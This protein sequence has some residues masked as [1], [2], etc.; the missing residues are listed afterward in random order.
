MLH[1]ILNNFCKYKSI[2]NKTN[3]GFL[4][5]ILFVILLSSCEKDSDIKNNIFKYNEYSNISSLDPAFSSTLRNIWPVNQIFNGLVQLDKNLEIKGDIASSW[6]ISEDKRTYTFKI[7][8]DV[9]FHNSELFGKNLTR[10]VK[11]KD[12]EYSFN[13][14]IDNKIASPGYWVLNNVKDF[15]AIND[16]IFQIEL[17]KEF[18]PFLGI[19]SMKYCSVVPHEIITV[20]GDKFSKKPIGTGPFKFKKW[21]EN[22]KLVL[23]KNKNY[24]ENDSLGQ[25]LPYLDGIAISFIPDKK[26]EFME[27]LSGRLDMVSSPDNSIIDQIF[28]YKGDLNPRFSSNYN[29]LKSP[30]LNTEYIG[31]NIQNNIKKDTLLRYAI[32]SGID[33]KKMMQYLRKNIGYPA[34]S[35]IVPNGLNNSFYSLRYNYDPDLSKKL[36]S[37]YKSNNDIDEINI[38]IFS[39]SQYLD[40]LEFIQSELQK[41][42]VQIQIEITPPSILRQGKATG[43]FDAFRA[44][45]IADYPHV[46]NYFSLF[47]SKNHTPKGPNYT[48]FSDRNFDEL[49]ELI[50][51][52]KSIS[53][54]KISNDLENILR[55]YSPIIPLY[56]DMSVRIVPKNI[57]GLEANAINQLN[58][59]RVMKKL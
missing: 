42:G 2:S 44:S 32:N 57:S 48:F 33:R 12:F 45:W 1:S 38:T 54:E 50:G 25:K 41:I 51:N 10:K 40:I 9:Y 46:E 23:S 55:R 11:A 31:F 13:R 37:I 6:T 26:S 53:Y 19:L 7:R 56:Y 17:K 43:K 16:S 39:D 34:E 30:Y 59:K 24:F 52:K 58:L 21:D 18:D 28:D 20:L 35:G 8:Q 27:L 29:L 49:Y 5:F 47:Y 15:K 36:I 4:I 22:V 14:L 3:I